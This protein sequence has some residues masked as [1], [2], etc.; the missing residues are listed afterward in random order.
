MGRVEAVQTN[1]MLSTRLWIAHGAIEKIKESAT[2]LTTAAERL[3]FREGQVRVTTGQVGTEI[4]WHVQTPSFSS[5]F[6]AVEQL[7]NAQTPIVLRFF[8][9]GWF[10]EF[11]NS[12]DEANRRIEEIISR[13]DR[14][15]PVKTFI[16]EVDPT[17]SGL[18]TVLVDILSAKHPPA[19]YSVDCIY[20]KIADRFDVDRIGAKSPIAKFYGTFLTSFPCAGTSYSDRVSEGYRHVLSTGKPR[21]DHVLAAFR[22]PDNEV[23]WVPYHR[24]IL[25]REK[26]GKGDSVSVVS[27][28]SAINFKVI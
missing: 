20:N 5:L 2:E 22:L 25:P 4:K 7:R 14:H 18:A 11:F 1:L 15:F 13:G 10:E 9:S 28:I 26:G 21:T 17:K 19:D 8:V 27:Q 3:R 12:A 16:E 24:L 6:V 23:H